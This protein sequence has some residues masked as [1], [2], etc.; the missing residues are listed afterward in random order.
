MSVDVVDELH[1]ELTTLD[2]HDTSAVRALALKFEALGDPARVA[3]ACARSRALKAAVGRLRAE[4]LAALLAR[5]AREDFI[6]LTAD[7]TYMAPV[8]LETL[9]VPRYVAVES[10][11][12]ACGTTLMVPFHKQGGPGFAFEC[13]ACATPYLARP[14]YSGHE[15]RLNVGVDTRPPKKRKRRTGVL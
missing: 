2:T 4:A 5:D 6:R 8:D 11:G 14:V 15:Y 13:P 12:C 3:E 10:Y 7:S 1:T 9:R